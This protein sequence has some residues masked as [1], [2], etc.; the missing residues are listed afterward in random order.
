LQLT[1]TS[2]IGGRRGRGGTRTF[3]ASDRLAGAPLDPAYR[4]A[5]D[6]EVDDAVR[7]AADAAP[8]YGALS[9][10]AKANFLGE[11]AGRIEGIADQL[12]ARTPLET[13]LPEGRIRQET[14]R[15]V[16][17]LRMFADLVA[18]GS[19]VDARID[20]GDPSRKPLP[21]PDIRSMLRALGPIATFAV[22]NFPIAFSAAGGDA[23]AALAAGNPVVLKAHP[24]HPGTAEI[25]AG[26]VRAAVEACGLPEG[27]FSLLYDDGI[28]V[29]RRLVA[30]RGIKGVAFTGSR[31]AGR[32]L[33]DLAAARPEPIPVFA[34]MSSVNPVFILPGAL[35]ARGPEIAQGLKASVT[36]GVG[37]FCTCPGLVFLPDSPAAEAFEAEFVK[38][39]QESPAA[40]MLTD[41]ISENYAR[42]L[43]RLADKPAVQVLCRAAGTGGPAVLATDVTSFLADDELAEELFGPSTLLVRGVGRETAMA[44]A[45]SLEGQLTATIHATHEELSG[46][47]ELA[48]LLTTRAGRVIYNG[49]PTGVEVCHAMVH[50][51]PYPATSDGRETSV[52]SAAIFRFTRRVC[53][54]NFPDAALPAELQ[55]ANPLGIR[56]LIDG[57]ISE[58]TS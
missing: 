3:H 18:E 16:G 40:A 34:E 42:G 33:M 4:A 32:A 2:F 26:A 56:R 7:L 36:L 13:G 24:A 41:A 23:A 46:W 5:S 50:G 53:F 10:R 35:A 39:M 30:H 17:Q 27:T 19:W 25:V 54:Q 22:S 21:K 38:L 29:G 49:F 45:A 51:G 9:G 20:H 14:A 57:T 37:Q 55:E 28:D 15:A 11:M 8:L 58:A 43:D 44:A 6:S 31:A 52:G 47:S 48:A 1:G 12:A